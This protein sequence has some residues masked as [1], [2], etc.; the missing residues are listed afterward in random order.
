MLPVDFILHEYLHKYFENI[1]KLED[2]FIRNVAWGPDIRDPPPP[3]GGY[4]GL[5]L[6]LCRFSPSHRN[7]ED[8]KPAKCCSDSKL[9]E[10]V[11]KQ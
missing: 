5:F 3:V 2:I 1:K 10:S 7:F 4:G 6:R 8:N 9:I 11:T